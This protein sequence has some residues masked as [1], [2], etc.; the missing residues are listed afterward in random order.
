[1]LR[2]LALLLFV[3]AG[4]TTSVQLGQHDGGT[5]EPCGPVLC[6]LGEVCCNPSCAICTAPGEACIE[7]TCGGPCDPFLAVGTGICRATLGFAWNGASC[8]PI[9]GCGCEGIDCA[10]LYPDPETCR[11]AH[12]GC[13]VCLADG[14]CPPEDF[15]S[16]PMGGCGAPTGGVG[17]CMPRPVPLACPAIYSPVCGCDG[18]TYDNECEAAMAGVSVLFPGACDACAPDDALPSGACDMVLGRVWNG[19]GCEEISGCGCVG[20]DCPTVLMPDGATC[21]RLH[22][23]CLMPDLPCGS[24]DCFRASEYCIAPDPTGEGVCQPSRCLPPSCDCVDVPGMCVDDGAGGIT[25]FR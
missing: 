23:G 15:C 17:N 14:D 19:M 3:Y 25:V 21:E 22:E 13:V 9:A 10:R 24:T 7:R 16:F 4:C 6:A 8:A 11:A 18:L 12:A 20:A 5:P 2:A 1:V